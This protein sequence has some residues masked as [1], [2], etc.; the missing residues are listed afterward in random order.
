MVS[1]MAKRPPSIPF[2][3]RSYP[4]NEELMQRFR[5][6]KNRSGRSFRWY[7]EQLPFMS[8]AGLL[9]FYSG[10]SRILYENGKPLSDWLDAHQLPV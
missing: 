6:H 9:K 8:T 5:C 1:S 7:A 10:Q 3:K 4:L 2:R